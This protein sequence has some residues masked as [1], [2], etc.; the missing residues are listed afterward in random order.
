MEVVGFDHYSVRA[1]TIIS[2]VVA[3]SLSQ[4]PSCK[5]AD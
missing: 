2:L 4:Y 3:L 1:E 5:K